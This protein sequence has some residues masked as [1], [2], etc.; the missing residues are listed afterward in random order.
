[1]RSYGN[2][3][4]TVNGIWVGTATLKNILALLSKCCHSQAPR[5]INSNHW[6]ENTYKKCSLRN[7]LLGQSNLD[8]KCVPGIIYKTNMARLFIKVKTG[9]NPK[10]HLQQN[11]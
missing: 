1:M 4:Y 7:F 11:G 6:L 2:S 8:Y 9:N 10:V 3:Y 5:Y